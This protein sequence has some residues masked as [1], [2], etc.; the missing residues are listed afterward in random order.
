[1]WYS[2]NG[3]KEKFD[4]VS[5]KLHCRK[6]NHEFEITVAQS[7][8]IPG[9]KIKNLADTSNSSIS[10][11]LNQLKNLLGSYGFSAEENYTVTGKSGNNYR[12]NIYGEDKLKRTVF[13]FIKN[14]TA[15]NDNSELNSKIIEVLDTSPTATI[16][17]GFPL[18]SE[19]AKTI[20]ANYNISLIT[21]KNPDKILSS[22]K[23]ILETKVSKPE[24]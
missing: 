22:I 18:I 5:I 6:F 12:I 23:E 24:D 9:F 3:C 15:E 14:P 1:M 21:E 4:D 11:I 7:L 16:L 17:I 10:P 13:I 8:L 20:T 2:C 19:K